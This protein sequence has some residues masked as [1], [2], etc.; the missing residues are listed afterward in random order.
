MLSELY[1]QAHHAHAREDGLNNPER[2]AVM[3]RI[4]KLVP[5]G[6]TLLDIGCGFGQYLDIA[7]DFGFAGLGVE[8]DAERAGCAASRGHEVVTGFFTPQLVSGRTFDAVLLSHVIE[9]L[10]Q[11]AEVLSDIQQVLKPGGTLFV[12]CPNHGGL[13]ARLMGAR[14]EHYSPPEHLNYFCQKSLQRLA[15][16]AGYQIV[17]IETFLHPLHVKELIA[18]LVYLRFLT[19]PRY[20]APSDRDCSV[21]NRFVNRSGGGGLRRPVYAML[22]AFCRVVAPLLGMVTGDRIHVFLRKPEEGW[23]G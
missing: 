5:D 19:A 2:L 22:M 11:P 8:P 12:A 3:R 13:R 23:K 21:Q 15:K 7:R 16:R 18:Y 17:R 9:H 20:S 4:R 10:R 14:Y 6:A 1:S